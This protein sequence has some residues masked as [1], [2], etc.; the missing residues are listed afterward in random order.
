MRRLTIG[1][2]AASD[3]V[4]AYWIPFPYMDCLVGPQWERMYLVLLG[5][6]IP[7]WGDTKVGLPFSEEKGKG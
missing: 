3:S 2:E 7:K 1:A 6:D 4:A 5:L